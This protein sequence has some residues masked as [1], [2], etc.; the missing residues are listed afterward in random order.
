[1]MNLR[2]G[3]EVMNGMTLLRTKVV[4]LR[5]RSVPRVESLR[6]ELFHL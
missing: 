1:M 4:R 2:S 6:D 3:E 5:Y